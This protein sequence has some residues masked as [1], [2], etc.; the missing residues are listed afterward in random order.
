MQADNL[1]TKQVLPW[2]YA[3]LL[4][5]ALLGL[6]SISVAF[7]TPVLSPPPPVLAIEATVVDETRI[8]EEMQRLDDLEAQYQREQDAEQQR[9]RD[10]ADAAREARVLEE[11][12]LEQVAREREQQ[13]RQL[14]L[15][16]EKQAQEAAQRQADRKREED[17]ARERQAELKAQQVAE[18]KRLAALEVEREAAEAKRREA[19][20]KAEAKRQAEAAAEAKRKAEAE[21]QARRE[22]ELQDQLLAAI[23]EEEQAR[24]AAD[25][26]LL[27]RWQELIKQKIQRNW[28]RP[29]SATAGL[30]CDVSVR[31]IPGGEVVEVKIGECNGDAAVMRSIEAAVFKASPLPPPDDPSLFQQYLTLKFNP[32]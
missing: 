24:E 17:A 26:G 3:L 31:Q 28:V 1:I 15:E 11:Q 7:S 2:F 18:E 6:V 29:P 23:S 5:A 21:A 27:A 4:H 12:R 32:K 30:A 16:Q 14:K 8:R 9:L 10:E 20:A 13:A 25:S 22:A 19:E